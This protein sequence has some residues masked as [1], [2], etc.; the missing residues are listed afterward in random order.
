MRPHHASQLR[1]GFTL[2]ELLVVI[3]MIAILVGLLL[4]AVQAVREAARRAQCSNNLKQIGL[5]M[6]NYHGSRNT[7]PPGYVTAVSATAPGAELGPG[8][9]WG[10]LILAELEQKPIYDGVNFNLQ[11]TD[12]G[13]QTVRTTNISVYL[14]PSNA[15]TGPITLKNASG[16]VLVSDLSASQ[17]VASVGQFEPDDSPATNN[18]VYYRNSRISLCDITDG[19]SLTLMAGERSRNVANAAWA[20]V[21]PTA[22]PARTHCGET[23][24]AI[25]PPSWS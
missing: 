16:T 17:Y 25:R 5:A 21:I 19:S 23:R 3:A 4:P 14:C 15:F 1:R 18:G 11:L 12:P 8:W 24:N 22:S 20:G 7:F 13:S 6:H 10:A 2:I 9:G